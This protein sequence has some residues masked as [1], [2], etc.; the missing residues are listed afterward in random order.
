MSSVSTALTWSYSSWYRWHKRLFPFCF[1]N[2]WYFRWSDTLKT[3]NLQ[4]TLLF[5][6]INWFTEHCNGYV[7]TVFLY[8]RFFQ[9]NSFFVCF[10]FLNWHDA[11]H[12]LSN[13]YNIKLSFG[14]NICH[15]YKCSFSS[16]S[17]LYIYIIIGIVSNNDVILVT[18]AKFFYSQPVY[19]GFL[20]AIYAFLG[21]MTKH[22]FL[23]L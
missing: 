12:Q 14:V 10:H 1:L 17:N 8:C 7:I 5:D 22:S 4:S 3:W 19:V 6:F 2:C 18:Y 23:P 9:I 11:T 13:T 16:L 15:S 21:K 20:A